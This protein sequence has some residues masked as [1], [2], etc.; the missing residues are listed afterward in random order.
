MTTLK[1]D[2]ETISS[3]CTPPSATITAVDLVETN[4]PQVFDQITDI[5]CRSGIG[6]TRTLALT[7][8]YEREPQQEAGT[9]EEFIGNSLLAD[10]PTTDIVSLWDL[11]K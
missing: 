6:L 7:L 5:A 4:R 8:K 10:W 9:S 2:I 11:L 3:H 1:N